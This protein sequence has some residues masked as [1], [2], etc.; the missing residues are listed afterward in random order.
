[1]VSLSFF[2]EKA[3]YLMLNPRVFSFC[4]FTDKDGVDVVVWRLEASD[5]CTRANIGKKVE[6]SPQGQVEGDVTLAD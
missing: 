6:C 5:R 3:L 1:M 2:F 4:V